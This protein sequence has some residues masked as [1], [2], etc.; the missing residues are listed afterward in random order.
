MFVPLTVDD[1]LHRAETVFADTVA[2][3]DGQGDE[4]GSL[5]WSWGATTVG[6]GRARP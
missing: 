1:F 5:L 6:S 4:H 3:V 2:V